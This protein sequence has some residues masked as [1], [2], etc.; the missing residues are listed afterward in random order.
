ME[1]YEGPRKQRKVK[2]NPLSLSLIIEESVRSAKTIIRV[3]GRRERKRKREK[4]RENQWRMRI[5]GNAKIADIMDLDGI[6]PAYPP[7]ML[8]THVCELNQSPWDVVTFPTD[9][10]F[11]FPP[12]N[13]VSFAFLQPGSLYICRSME[14]LLRSILFSPAFLASL[15][16]RVFS[17]FRSLGFREKNPKIPSTSV[18]FC[19][20]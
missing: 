11:T 9:S 20:D 17:R 15:R 4:L 7:E 8:Q 5:R 3:E 13:R 1:I 12:E 14:T 16:T 6:A 2:K 10:T 18:V 19:V